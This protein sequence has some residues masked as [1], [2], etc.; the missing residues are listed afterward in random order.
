MSDWRQLPGARCSSL[1]GSSAHRFSVERH[2]KV[3]R[4]RY[5]HLCN[6]PSLCT[7]RPDAR[8]RKCHSLPPILTCHAASC[9]VNQNPTISSLPDERLVGVLSQFTVDLWSTPRRCAGRLCHTSVHRWER[10]PSPYLAPSTHTDPPDNW[11]VS[12]VHQLQ[13]FMKSSNIYETFITI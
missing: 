12:L 9:T 2:P 5:V 1:L 3:Y 4:S 7:T 10:I 11:W 8:L 6:A 13:R